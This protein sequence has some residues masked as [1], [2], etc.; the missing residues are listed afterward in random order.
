MNAMGGKK[1]TVQHAV[2]EIESFGHPERFLVDIA[3][4]DRFQDKKGVPG[5]V[6]KM[7][8]PTKLALE[9]AL[10]EEQE[11]RALEANCGC[12]NG[13]GKKPRRLRRYRTTSFCRKGR[14]TSS[15]STGSAPYDLVGAGPGSIPYS[16]SF[17]A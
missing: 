4:G 14:R 7:P 12:W 1:E 3:E 15:G 17:G 8:K 5:Y 6:N 13:P 2:N 16:C 9:M 11:R 10:H